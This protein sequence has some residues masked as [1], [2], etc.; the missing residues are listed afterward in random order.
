M[1][2]IKS[3]ERAFIA[4]LVEE[5]KHVISDPK[6]SF[7]QRL[8]WLQAGISKHAGRAAKLRRAKGESKHEERLT[9][10]DGLIAL[11]ERA[12]AYL[13]ATVKWVKYRERHPSTL[14]LQETPVVF[15]AATWQP[16]KE[17]ATSGGSSE[18]PFME[19]SS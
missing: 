2:I 5:T 14:T 13:R 16:T 1:R 12:V 4:S 10:L 6:L 17:L 15:A 11:R 8:E 9:K 7:Q 19:F 18:Y 3:A